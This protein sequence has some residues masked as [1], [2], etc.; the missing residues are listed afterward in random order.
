MWFA[1]SV[2]LN[3]QDLATSTLKAWTT[4]TAVHA[5]AGS[6]A[7]QADP[8]SGEACSLARRATTGASTEQAE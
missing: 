4:L 2:P 8:V 6:I 5:P 3:A 7:S 1:M